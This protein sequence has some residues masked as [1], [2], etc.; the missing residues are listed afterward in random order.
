VRRT[1]DRVCFLCFEFEKAT[2]INKHPGSLKGRLFA[3]TDRECLLLRHISLCLTSCASVGFLFFFQHVVTLCR[4]FRLSSVA[5]RMVFG[6]KRNPEKPCFS[7]SSLSL[8]LSK[9]LILGTNFEGRKKC[10]KPNY[11]VHHD[12]ACC[13]A[14]AALPTLH[15]TA[16]S[17]VLATSQCCRFSIGPKQGQ[18]GICDA[19]KGEKENKTMMIGSKK[20]RRKHL[21]IPRGILETCQNLKRKCLHSLRVQCTM[22][23]P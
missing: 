20:C 5:R 22:S 15:L 23:K 19:P 17:L 6:R 12:D 8:S 10:P 13:F 4:V 11:C 16:Y 1:L 14:S 21:K 3:I 18:Q 7:S 2:N 9:V